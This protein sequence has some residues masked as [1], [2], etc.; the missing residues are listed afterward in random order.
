MLERGLC[1]VPAGGPAVPAASTDPDLP[2]WHPGVPDESDA[3]YR[4]YVEFR[5]AANVTGAP[6]PYSDADRIYDFFL[7][8]RDLPPVNGT[9]ATP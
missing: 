9:V 1:V 4:D 8:Y 5:A 2:D 3:I 7:G 6:D